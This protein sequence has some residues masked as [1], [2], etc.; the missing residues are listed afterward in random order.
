[1]CDVEAN[2]KRLASTCFFA[3][4]ARK[5]VSIEAETVINAMTE[6]T[7]AVVATTTAAR[8]PDVIKGTSPFSVL[9]NSL[10]LRLYEAP[11]SIE[12]T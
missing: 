6:E 2:A 11:E 9:N 4:A 8:L 7:A 3:T 10:C 5:E 12:G 1:M